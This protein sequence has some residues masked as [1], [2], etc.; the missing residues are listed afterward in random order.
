MLAMLMAV[1]L[2]LINC[3]S[4]KTEM[5]WKNSSS[6]TLTEV[7]WRDKNDSVNQSWGALSTGGAQSD[8]KE[9]SALLGK[10]EGVNGV[11]EY[12]ILVQDQNGDGAP[13]ESFEVPEGSANLYTITSAIAK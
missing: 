11:N 1:S 10:G 3:N 6:Q 2:V 8:M 12:R 9:V 4:K 5:G 13:D 7:Q